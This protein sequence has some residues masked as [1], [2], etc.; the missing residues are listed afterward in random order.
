MEY[1][2]KIVKSTRIYHVTFIINY[3]FLS[4]YS[5]SMCFWN[6]C[7]FFLY[8]FFLFC[9][10]TF[11][12]VAKEFSFQ[13]QWEFFVNFFFFENPQ[14][15]R[16]YIKKSARC[17]VSRRHFKCC[18]LYFAQ[19]KYI[20][21]NHFH[22]R[23]FR[24]PRHSV[25]TRTHIHTQREWESERDRKKE[26]IGNQQKIK[27]IKYTRGMRKEQTVTSFSKWLNIFNISLV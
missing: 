3:I 10:K 14:I 1:Q 22:H 5:F 18:V 4:A 16:I 27:W 25:H 24:F 9:I 26:D 21:Q 20:F 19:N 11:V 7:F 15:K 17:Y 6:M 13:N 8:I 23:H 12:L 2:P